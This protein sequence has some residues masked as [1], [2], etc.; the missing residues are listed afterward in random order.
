VVPRR[1]IEDLLAFVTTSGDNRG[2][3][4]F[5]IYYAHQF[6]KFNA[7]ADKL[8]QFK[9]VCAKKKRN[10]YGRFHGLINFLIH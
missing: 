2:F 3:M 4:G 1:Q 10:I 5:G 6:E 7:L 9:N 8:A